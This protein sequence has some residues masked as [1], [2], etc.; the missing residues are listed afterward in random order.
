MRT[1]PDTYLAMIEPL[2]ITFSRLEHAILRLQACEY[3]VSIAEL[4]RSKLGFI[5]K[6]CQICGCTDVLGCQDDCAWANREQ[7]L[8]T[9]CAAHLHDRDQFPRDT[10]TRK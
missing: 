9:R 1:I 4:V 10:Q 8:C 6:T 5:E 3:G 7:T 2:P